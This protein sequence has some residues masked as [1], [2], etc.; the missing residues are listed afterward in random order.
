[1]FIL[2]FFF[3]FELH[4]CIDNFL[5]VAVNLMLLKDLVVVKTCNV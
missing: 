5:N 1:M 4:M 3:F 2:I